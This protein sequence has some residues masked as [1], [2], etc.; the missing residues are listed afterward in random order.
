M[1]FASSGL[2]LYD[3]FLFGTF[4]FWAV[5]VFFAAAV[6]VLTEFEKGFF[7]FLTMLMGCAIFQLFG[8]TDILGYIWHN[9]IW[10][11]VWVAAYFAGGV[12]YSLV[13]WRGYASDQREKYEDIKER[14]LVDKG[15][16]ATAKM[17]IPPNLAAEWE[18]Y[19]KDYQG[20]YG[21]CYVD[22]L[23]MTLD[24]IKAGEGPQFRNNKS[25]CMTWMT[26]WPFS[27]FWYLLNDPVRRV[28]RK[29]MNGLRGAYEA[30]SRHAW[31]G[32]SNDFATPPVEKKV[33]STDPPP[34]GPEG[35]PITMVESPLRPKASK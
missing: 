10:A 8:G 9:P 35:V 25:R 32:V 19:L 21:R 27:A 33:E 4:W 26:Y 34:L 23:E 28:F 15:Q 2:H 5:L 16:K 13:R 17:V 30:I 3:V 31:Q 20:R 22:G 24:E 6:I 29:A 1:L 11:V 12:L 18:K 7:A 14:W